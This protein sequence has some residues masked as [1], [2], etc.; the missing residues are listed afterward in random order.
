M[1]K[2]VKEHQL[3]LT[4]FTN[5]YNAKPQYWATLLSAKLEHERPVKNVA[6]TIQRTKDV[7]RVTTS[8]S[9]IES[10][11]IIVNNKLPIPLTSV[12]NI[13]FAEDI[14]QSTGET[15]KG[16]SIMM[17]IVLAALFFILL[18]LFLVSI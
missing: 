16:G 17:L 15:D 3:A 6:I 7:V 4:S 5:A 9:S 14:K 13:E 12:L 2:L 8:V 11:F 1:V 10:A 18:V